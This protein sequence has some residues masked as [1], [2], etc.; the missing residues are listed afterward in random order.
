M[1]SKKQLAVTLSMLNKIESINRGLEQY[2]TDSE[3]A[4]DI[5]W[6]AFMNQDIDK[7]EIYDLG[8]GN[9][10]LG[11]GAMIMGAE[12]CNFIDIDENAIDILKSNIADEIKQK[13]TIINKDINEVDFKLM[14][15]IRDK[16]NDENI[17]KVVIMNPPFGTKN[18]H[19][20]R[21]FLE[22]AFSFA[23]IVYSLHLEESIDFLEK[24]STE[25]NFKITNTIKYDFKIK[26][27]H[28][29]HKKNNL[30]VP[31]ICVRLIRL[32]KD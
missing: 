13:C 15:N 18:I 23:D 22:K 4:A 30:I 7:S 8:C 1:R 31:I 25:N 11:V 12:S 2:Q 24:Y 29:K 16:N 3:L 9:G 27:S 28:A 32:N 10:I 20:D 5:I 26:K 6:N 19:A 21:N 14:N 17:K